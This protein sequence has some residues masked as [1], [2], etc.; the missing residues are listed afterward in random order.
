MDTKRY[1]KQLLDITKHDIIIIIS[2]RSLGYWTHMTGVFYL[3]YIPS[4]CKN[5]VMGLKISL[6]KSELISIE[7]ASN[8]KET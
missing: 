5:A 4:H 1:L 2:L 3:I 6:E 8:V 7:R